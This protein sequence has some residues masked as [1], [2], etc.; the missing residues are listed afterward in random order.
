MRPGQF[1]FLPAAFGVVLLFS[2]GITTPPVHAVLE[3]LK[4]E[5][6]SQESRYKALIA[7]LRC[8]VCQNQ[9]LADSNAELARDLRLL[10][11]NMI[12]SGS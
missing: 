5:S 4:F 2:A 6:S 11:Y 9:N 3:P 1:G 7:E 8:L 10:T 12:L